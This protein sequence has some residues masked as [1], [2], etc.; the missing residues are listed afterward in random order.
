MLNGFG[1]VMS[2]LKA[3][4][5]RLIGQLLMARNDLNQLA[6]SSDAATAAKSQELLTNQT[7]LETELGEVNTV[8]NSG[9][10]L[11]IPDYAR[12][13]LFMV[14]VKTQVDAVDTLKTGASAESM[15]TIV[16]AGISVGVLAIGGL[17]L[18]LGIKR[19]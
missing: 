3:K 6:M 5:Q 12:I 13:S 8:L 11:S 18:W 15:P 16:K 4:A 9:E 17:L 14:K 1:T 10:S 19:R 2:D 7:E